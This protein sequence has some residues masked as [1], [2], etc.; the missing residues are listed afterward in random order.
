MFQVAFYTLSTFLATNV[1]SADFF[2]WYSTDRYEPVAN[3]KCPRSL[4]PAGYRYAP[5][6]SLHE[7]LPWVYSWVYSEYKVYNE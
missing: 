7:F 2:H 6:N 3:K 4:L 1:G 5:W